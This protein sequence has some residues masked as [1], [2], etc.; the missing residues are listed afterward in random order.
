MNRRDLIRL[1]VSPRWFSLGDDFSL[2]IEVRVVVRL[3]SEGEYRLPS[4]RRSCYMVF[5]NASHV[6]RITRTTVHSVT[7]VARTV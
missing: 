2:R 4:L 7:S 6:N 5:C 1:D 3:S